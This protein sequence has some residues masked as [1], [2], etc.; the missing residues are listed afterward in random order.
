LPYSR[1]L[2]RSHVSD[3]LAYLEGIVNHEISR[4]FVIPGE[5]PQIANGYNPALVLKAVISEKAVEKFTHRFLVR[6]PS[7][8][9]VHL[10]INGCLVTHES[11]IGALAI[12]EGLV[13][14]QRKVLQG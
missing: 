1:K 12:H 8:Y 2:R 13:E 6:S 14:L 5:A 9:S 3:V 11:H 10:R 4:G 7:I